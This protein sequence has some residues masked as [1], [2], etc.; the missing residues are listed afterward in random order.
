MAAGQGTGD[1]EF[2][3]VPGKPDESILPY[4]M[5]STNPAEMMPELG[6]ATFHREGVELIREWIAA[7][8]GSCGSPS[9][10]ATPATP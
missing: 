4:R 5:V 3:I 7:Q 8:S 1:R 6:R 2:D 10:S 9:S